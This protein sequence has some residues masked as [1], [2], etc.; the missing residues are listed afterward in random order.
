V[1]EY[2]WFCLLER[3]SNNTSRLDV[4][5]HNITHNDAPQ[6]YSAPSQIGGKRA[7]GNKNIPEIMFLLGR[8]SDEEL[9]SLEV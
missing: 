6:K 8:D 3:N 5:S 1:K 7:M 4:M 9:L 2:A